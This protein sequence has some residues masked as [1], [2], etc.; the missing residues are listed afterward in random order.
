LEHSFEISYLLLLPD[1][2]GSPVNAKDD[3]A[4]DNPKDHAAQVADPSADTEIEMTS[5]APRSNGSSAGASNR[6]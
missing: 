1:D 4:G 2:K 6:R 3:A 5:K